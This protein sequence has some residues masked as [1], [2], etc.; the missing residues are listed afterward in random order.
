MG[1]HNLG[2]EGLCNQPFKCF[3]CL[4]KLN[5]ENKK[6]ISDLFFDKSLPDYI[7]HLTLEIPPTLNNI[8]N[9]Y[10]FDGV[11]TILYNFFKLYNR[12]VIQDLRNGDVLFRLS[13]RV[14][15]IYSFPKLIL[16]FV[17]L[18]KLSDITLKTFEDTFKTLLLVYTKGSGKVELISDLS[19]KKILNHLNIDYLLGVSNIEIN[20]FPFLNSI[21]EKQISEIRSFLNFPFSKIELKHVINNPLMS[22]FRKKIL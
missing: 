6:V 21:S 22:F 13:L 9:Y 20:N 11:D 19:E 5:G 4:E 17:F 10:S 16:E 8:T 18:K 12:V 2:S 1:N 14:D 3:T 7:T 15:E